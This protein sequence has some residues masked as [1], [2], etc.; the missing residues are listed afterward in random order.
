VVGS[1]AIIACARADAFVGRALAARPLVG[2][3]LVSYSAYLWHQP[4]FALARLRSI[5]EPSAASFAVLTLLT[6]ALAYLT[7]RHVETPFRK[8]ASQRVVIASSVSATAILFSTGVSAALLFPPAEAPQPTNGRC[9]VGKGDCFAAAGALRQVALWGDS[10][11][12]AFASSLGR[13]LAQ[14][15]IVLR[16]FV[17]NGCPSLMG[18]TRN[19]AGAAGE[20]C[21]AHNMM[22]LEA[23]RREKFDFVVL[24]S[25]YQTYLKQS[26]ASGQPLLVSFSGAA[27][28]PSRSLSDHLRQTIVATGSHVLLVTPHPV[29]WDFPTERKKLH[30]G[31]VNQIYADYA[32]ATAA[33]S[34]VLDGLSGVAFDEIDG[35]E[36]LCSGGKCP[37]VAGPRMLLY[38]GSHLGP[39]LS[40]KLAARITD[41]IV[42]AT[43]P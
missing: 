33:R 38:D 12:D 2:I 6:F 8:A 31:L 18:L 34:M 32:A 11:A 43:T 22:A 24:T 30:F 36:L 25:A 13:Q 1:A 37:I 23:I 35:R 7:W 26:S 16:L 10:Y 14:H 5:E 28:N 9:N 39:Y 21:S 27:A 40:E 19:D 29:V 3:G 42:R 20:E 41:V 17:R 4:L 15:G